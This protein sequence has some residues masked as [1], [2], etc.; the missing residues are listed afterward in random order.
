MDVKVFMEALEGLEEKGITKDVV[1]DAM[2][3]AL[4]NAC[5]QHFGT[6][7]SLSK[8]TKENLFIVYFND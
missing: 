7:D 1:F 8:S 4:L 3:E 5:K 6:R 2:E